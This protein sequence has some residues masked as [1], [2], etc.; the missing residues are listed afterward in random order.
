MQ[1]DTNFSSTSRTQRPNTSEISFDQHLKYIYDEMDSERERGDVIY[2]MC[3]SSNQ[4]IRD[5]YLNPLVNVIMQTYSKDAVKSLTNP[6]GIDGLG[7]FEERTFRKVMDPNNKFHYAQLAMM[8]MSLYVLR[9]F[10]QYF[11]KGNPG[12]ILPP[13]ANRDKL[14]LFIR[15]HLRQK[16]EDLLNGN[17]LKAETIATGLDPVIVF[18]ETLIPLY[19]E[20]CGVF[21][22]T[23]VT[24]K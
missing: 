11:V 2:A 21:I 5:H 12:E 22:P 16:C 24:R 17:I 19:M 18:V 13:V 3:D 4:Q 10:R 1:T 6:D 9:S 7:E 8:F 23:V 15:T 20:T 14:D